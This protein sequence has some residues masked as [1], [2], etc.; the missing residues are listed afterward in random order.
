M[1]QENCTKRIE[2]YNVLR[3]NWPRF[4]LVDLWSKYILSQSIE[5]ESRERFGHVIWQNPKQLDCT[6]T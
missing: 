6:K 3:G 2:I 4:F 5:I 1:E